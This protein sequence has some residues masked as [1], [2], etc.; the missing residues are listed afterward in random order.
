L[1]G[2]DIDEVLMRLIVGKRFKDIK[3]DP[4]A[5]MRLKQAAID[6]KIA[7]GA[8][9]TYDLRLPFL[10]ADG[11][12]I[13]MNVTRGQLEQAILPLVK[14]TETQISTALSD[15]GLAESDLDKVLLV[16]GT[17]R[18]PLVKRVVAEIIGTVPNATD[19]PE[20]TV[21]RGAALQAAIL[22]GE[23][24]AEQSVVLT[25]VCPFTLGSEVATERGIVVDPLIKR[26]TT[27]PCEFS[28]IYEASMEY[29]P[30]V[31]I[32]AYQ[33]EEDNPFENSR[34]GV[35]WLDGLPQRRG[36]RAKIE[37]TFAYD[38]NGILQ[39][40]G[41]ALG[42]DKTSSTSIN[43]TKQTKRESQPVVLAEWE[44]ATNAKAY[45]PLIKKVLKVTDEFIGTETFIYEHLYVA[46]NM[47]DELK[48]SLILGDMERVG[49]LK[50]NLETFL[51]EWKNREAEDDDFDDDFADLSE[52]EMERLL[53]FARKWG[54][55]NR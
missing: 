38:L 16:G 51:E 23:L 49:E 32:I 11:S 39:V 37:V 54:G 7:L 19:F 9:E 50:K 30:G 1:G 36:Q 26:N 45:R 20:L 34:I 10:F 40:T 42:N 27:I 44:N 3:Q 41:R 13:V 29:Q 6:C 15:A 22:A 35:L 17:T 46:T 55:P 18:I 52:E 48:A 31:E 8:S 24:E 2:K 5:E 14:S 47:V 33:G 4:R 53:K 25:D 12:G 21:A 28:K 43:V